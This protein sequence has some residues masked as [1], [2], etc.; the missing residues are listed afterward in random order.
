[1]V[2]RNASETLIT[3]SSPATAFFQAV[4]LKTNI[5]R[6]VCSFGF[7]NVHSGPVASPA[8]INQ[9]HWTEMRRIQDGLQC[10]VDP[11]GFHRADM[12]RTGPMT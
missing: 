7:D 9:I 12:M 2:T 1:V 8:E 5:E 3:L 11:A 6:A 10:L 4:R